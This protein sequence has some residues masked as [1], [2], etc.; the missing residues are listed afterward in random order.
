[1]GA[2]RF[3]MGISAPVRFARRKSAVATQMSV[4]LRGDQR[5]AENFILEVRALAERCGLEIPSVQITRQPAVGSKTKK[6]KARSRRKA[7]S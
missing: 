1:M 6:K 3:E 4:A 7:G 2:E 5:M